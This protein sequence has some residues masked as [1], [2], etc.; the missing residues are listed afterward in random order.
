MNFIFLILQI[1]KIWLK[2]VPSYT[3]SQVE[4][5]I[6]VRACLIL[7]I[8][9]INIHHSHVVYAI[10]LRT[11]SVGISKIHLCFQLSYCFPVVSTYRMNRFLLSEERRKA[12]LSNEVVNS[13]DKTISDRGKYQ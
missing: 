8:C 1:R 2:N 10:L 13:K 12:V 5:R 3:I 11:G 7:I 6:Q 9:S 4:V